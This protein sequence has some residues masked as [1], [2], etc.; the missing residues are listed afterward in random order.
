MGTLTFPRIAALEV[1]PVKLLCL[2]L[3]RRFS[4]ASDVLQYVVA[5]DVLPAVVGGIE[6]EN[7]SIDFMYQRVQVL[8]IDIAV[9]PGAQSWDLE[10]KLF[11]DVGIDPMFSLIVV[12]LFPQ[13]FEKRVVLADSVSHFVY[14]IDKARKQNAVFLLRAGSF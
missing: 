11:V 3:Q 1:G 5:V 6:I 9:V 12:A 2:A 4:P 13:M 8:V 10:V 7:I 14:G